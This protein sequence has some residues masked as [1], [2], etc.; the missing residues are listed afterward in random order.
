MTVRDDKRTEELKLRLT[1]R[2]L[3]DL[4]R[5]A[6]VDERSVAEYVVRMLRGAMYGSVAVRLASLEGHTRAGE[7]Q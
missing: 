6:A 5:L 7:S 4:S 3:L 1:E 2:E